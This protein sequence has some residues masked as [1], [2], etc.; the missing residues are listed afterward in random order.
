MQINRSFN[1]ES[2]PLFTSYISR[3]L[4]N[5]R[6]HSNLKTTFVYLR[7]RR[8][9]KAGAVDIQDYASSLE[10][11]CTLLIIMLKFLMFWVAALLVY[12]TYYIIYLE[13]MQ[14]KYS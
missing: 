4:V 10:F 1:L 13:E 6:D 14:T 12:Y 2:S 9:A 3:L 7:S 8:L 11:F 5:F